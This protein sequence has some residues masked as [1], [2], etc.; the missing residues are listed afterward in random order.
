MKKTK[1]L[2]TLTISLTAVLLACN[3]ETKN[4]EERPL[5]KKV[6]KQKKAH[7]DKKAVKLAV[8]V[9]DS[10]GGYDTWQKKRYL[11]WVFFGMRSWIWDK[12][13][14]DVRMHSRKD[15]L[16]ILMNLKTK[17]G[18]VFKGG[19]KTTHPDSIDKY[20]KVGYRS[21]ANDAY[22]VFMPFKLLD[23]GVQLTYKGKEAA[24][25][26][27]KAHLIR[28]QFDSVGVTPKNQYDVFIDPDRMLVTGW[29]Y[30]REPGTK[31][32]LTTPWTGY[33]N[34]NGIKLASSRGG[35]YKIKEIS[36]RDSIN[37]EVFDI[38]NPYDSLR[39]KKP[40]KRPPS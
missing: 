7:S 11:S 4:L 35:K 39:S 33:R 9:T 23:P 16:T 15:S 36:V 34:Y 6:Y 28:V 8:Q 5:F 19:E 17:K 29:K 30:Y 10:M 31:P 27:D 40:G 1:L 2:I 14:G 21:W 25:T 18:K 22:W 26:G 32:L 12:K 37:R 3:N 20:L 13:T 24:P 38:Y